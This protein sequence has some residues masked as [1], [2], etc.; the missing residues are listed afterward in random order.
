MYHIFG[1]CFIDYYFILFSDR[2]IYINFL[3][4]IMFFIIY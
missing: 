2:R 1:F 3:I 4:V